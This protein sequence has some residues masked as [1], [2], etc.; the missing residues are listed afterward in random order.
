M[1]NPIFDVAFAGAEAARG[2]TRLPAPVPAARHAS[3]KP[4]VLRDAHVGSTGGPSADPPN[5]SYFDL[6]G[7]GGQRVTVH[8]TDDAVH[9][10][11][12][13]LMLNLDM[14]H[15]DVEECD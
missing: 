7:R 15:F 9:D 4:I 8:M 12:H 13:D 3:L 1:S 6:I 10:L 5:G 2:E 14:W 11:I